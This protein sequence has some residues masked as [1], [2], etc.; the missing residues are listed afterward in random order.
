MKK[1][2]NIVIISL[3]ALMVSCRNNGTNEVSNAAPNTPKAMQESIVQMEDSI[4][5]LDPSKVKPAAYNLNQ[6]ELINRLEA[7]V[8]SFPKDPYSADCLFKLHM[9][10]SGLNAQRKSVACGDSLLRLFPNYVNKTLLLESMASAYDMFI[11]PRDTAAVRK[12][13]TQLLKD[14]KYSEDKKQAVKERLKFLDLPWMEYVN[15]K[16]SR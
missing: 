9:I 2:F 10:Y 4:A 6:I 7:Y 16:Q 3:V 8:K 13:Y 14:S 11:T 5:K 12:Y 15:R 1:I